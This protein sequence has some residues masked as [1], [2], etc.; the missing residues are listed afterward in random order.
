MAAEEEVVIGTKTGEIL[1]VNWDGTIDESF[2]WK[3][4]TPQLSLSTTAVTPKNESS[5]FNLVDLKYSSM[6]GG[7]AMVFSSGRAAFMPLHFQSSV[8]P[9]PESPALPTYNSRLQFVHD[10]E[11]AVSTAINHKYQLIAFGL[12]NAEGILCCLDDSANSVITTHKL[13]LPQS[14]FP[15]AMQ[16]AGSMTQLQWTPDSMVLAT[17]WEKGAFALWSVFGALLVC[18]LS[19]DFGLLDN[20]KL[21]PFK[22]L[23]IAWGKEG[24]H[25]WLSTKR[26]KKP[27]ETTKD[28]NGHF[29]FPD[30]VCKM[31][32][33]KSVLASNP[34]CACSEE[35]VL[36]VAEDRLFLGVGAVNNVGQEQSYSS[37][38]RSKKLNFAKSTNT[39][40]DDDV[41]PST[42]VSSGKI[43]NKYNN[44]IYK[45]FNS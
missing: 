43:K 34:S 2:R 12:K 28:A 4:N 39:S 24:Y 37:P 5:E 21:N 13:V 1:G 23:S 45:L 44:F 20:M 18:S 6:I 25:L 33:A 17:A 41:L 42:N 38:L 16:T 35:L 11:N 14:A 8:P 27:A 15:D 10:T 40:F 32:I 19:W 36:L 7:F 31:K 9:T 3:L 26:N 22:V 30:G 29:K